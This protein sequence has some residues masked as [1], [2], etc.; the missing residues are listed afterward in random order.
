MPDEELLL[1]ADRGQLAKP[2]QVE[3]QIARLLAD[4]RAA[5]A[6]DEFLAQWMRFDRL[7]SAMTEETRRLFRSLVWEDRNFLEFFTADY[8]YL[9]PELAKLYGRPAPR[10]A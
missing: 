8:A 7:R 4:P 10:E 5:D 3:K 9:S 6:F 2:E 1:A